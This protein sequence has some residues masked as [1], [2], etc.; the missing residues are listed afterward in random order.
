MS[1]GLGQLTGAV[2]GVAGA[3]TKKYLP[4]IVPG[5]AGDEVAPWVVGLMLD[6]VALATGSEEWNYFATGFGG[7]LTG[8][9]V[10][11]ILP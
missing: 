2:G 6:G 1:L 4:R 9:A 3:I 8:S 11:K 10:E 7:Y 5:E